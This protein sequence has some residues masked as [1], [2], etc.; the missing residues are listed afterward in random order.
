MPRTRADALFRLQL[1]CSQQKFGDPGLSTEPFGMIAD[2]S[3]SKRAKEAFSC[4]LEDVVTSG[5]PK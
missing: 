1:E 3:R 5:M 4:G 2:V